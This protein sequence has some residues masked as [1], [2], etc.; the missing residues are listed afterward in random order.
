MFKL[1][2]CYFWT[3]EKN[4]EKRKTIILPLS[5]VSVLFWD[6][7]VSST[8]STV[9]QLT[10]LV[11]VFSCDS[12]DWTYTIMPGLF[13]NPLNLP[14]TKLCYWQCLTRTT[15]SEPN[16]ISCP[17]SRV[18]GWT[19][20]VWQFLPPLRQISTLM[21]FPSHS[22]KLP[23]AEPDTTWQEET[24]CEHV[25]LSLKVLPVY[26]YHTYIYFFFHKWVLTKFEHLWQLDNFICWSWA[27]T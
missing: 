19:I 21:P 4:K 7:E 25:F 10:L 27:A 24:E 14:G 1:F 16:V 26:L 6:V 2:G 20:P 15:P 17:S 11:L 22:S 8:E 18:K 9:R 5:S 23:Q 3:P 12:Q 13:S